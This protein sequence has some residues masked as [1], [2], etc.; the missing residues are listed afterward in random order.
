METPFLCWMKFIRLKFVYHVYGL[1]SMSVGRGRVEMCVFSTKLI[2]LATHS[3]L[4]YNCMGRVPMSLA[5]LW[6]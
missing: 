4:S 6:T 1:R 3:K 2:K 5:W